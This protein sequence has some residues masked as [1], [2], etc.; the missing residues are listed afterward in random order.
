MNGLFSL[1]CIQFLLFFV[2]LY[3]SVLLVF[4]CVLYCSLFLY[5]TVSACVVR[6]ATLT[7]VLLA[8]SS[9]VRQVPGYNSQRRGTART[10]EISFKFVDGYVYFY[11]FF[12]VMYLSLYSVYCVCVCECMLYCC[13]RVSTQLQLNIYHFNF[14]WHSTIPCARGRISLLKIITRILLG[15]K[16]PG[17]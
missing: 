1:L 16:T 11:L 10:S 9:V 2:T 8:F 13:H 4:F 12:V 6:A 5:C 3:Y 7:Q 14:P 15:V 17:A